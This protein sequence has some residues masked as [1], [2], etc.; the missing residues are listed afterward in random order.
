MA[1]KFNLK[2][3]YLTLEDTEVFDAIYKKFRNALLNYIDDYHLPVELTWGK[4]TT[5][6]DHGVY[7]KIYEINY[8]KSLSWIVGK[9]RQHEP[10]V[11][12]TIIK[13]FLHVNLITNIHD[14]CS[15]HF[16]LFIEY[17]DGKLDNTPYNRNQIEIT[18]IAPNEHFNDIKIA[19][20]SL[21]FNQ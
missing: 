7:L 1:E 2:T 6:P 18:L 21:N 3:G 14:D 11:L 16:A 4:S 5:N 15:H 20:T 9:T 17:F 10:Y 13:S 8:Q 12:D 19:I